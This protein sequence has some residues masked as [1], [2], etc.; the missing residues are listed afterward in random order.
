MV[1]EAADNNIVGETDYI[2]CN[3]MYETDNN[4]DGDDNNIVGYDW[5]STLTTHGTSS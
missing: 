2:T 4:I 1:R 5:L 3:V